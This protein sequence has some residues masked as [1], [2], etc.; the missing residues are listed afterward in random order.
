MVVQPATEHGFFF[1][2]LCLPQYGDPEAALV[3]HPANLHVP[4][5][6]CF[7]HT[8]C[9]CARVVQPSSL[10]TFLAVLAAPASSANG[11]G[12][13]V[14]KRADLL[15]A[16]CSANPSCSRVIAAAFRRARHCLAVVFLALPSHSAGVV[17][18]RVRCAVSIG[19]V[20]EADKPATDLRGVA[21]WISAGH[22]Y[23]VLEAH[24]T[25]RLSRGGATFSE[26]L[27]SRPEKK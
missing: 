18:A 19:A 22:L 6:P 3:V 11:T 8:P 23:A 14:V 9:A 7:S 2:P 21:V 24:A 27:A 15:G 20:L 4:F 10:H 17:D 16:M 13:V 12:A 25:L 1:P 26:T 5:A